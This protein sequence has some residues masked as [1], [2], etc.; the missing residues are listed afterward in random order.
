MTDSV[1]AERLQKATRLF[2]QPGVYLRN[3]AHIEIRKRAVHDLLGDVRGSVL[4][5]GCGDGRVGLSFVE[6]AERVTLVD[7][8]GAMLQLAESRIPATARERVTLCESDLDA[9][10]EPSMSCFASGS[11]P[12]FPTSLVRSPSWLG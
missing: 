1:H 2:E 9:F 4:D 11:W 5:M 6:D 3:D 7:P 8:A 12:M 10:E